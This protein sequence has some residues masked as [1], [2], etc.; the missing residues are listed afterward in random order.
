MQ[1]MLRVIDT[2]GFNKRLFCVGFSGFLASSYGLFA[3]NVI[4]PALEFDYPPCGRLSSK[5]S[6]VIDQLTLIGTVLGMFCAGHFADLWG[7]KRLYGFELVILIIATLGVV[8]ASEGLRLAEYPDGTTD[9]TMDIYSWIAWWRFVLGIGIGA[10]VSTAH[11]GCQGDLT[12]SDVSIRC[13]QSSRQN[14]RQQDPE[15]GCSRQCLLCKQ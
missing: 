15:E 11:W 4:N 7:R 14:G 10:E 8:Q 9:S 5:A 12:N 2:G 6:A 1:Q 13:R 3:T